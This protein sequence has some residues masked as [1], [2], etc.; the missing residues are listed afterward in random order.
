MAVGKP[1]VSV[2]PGV[3]SIDVAVSLT[4]DKPNR[5]VLERRSFTPPRSFQIDEHMVGESGAG[6][7]SWELSG[8]NNG[9]RDGTSTSTHIYVPSSQNRRV[10]AYTLAGVRDPDEDYILI[11]YHARG[12]DFVGT[13]LY[14]VDDPA[15]GT[16]DSRIYVYTDKTGTRDGS[17]EFALPQANGSPNGLYSDGTTLYIPDNDGH[18]Y[19]Y[20]ISTEAAGTTIDL[21]SD[22]TAPRGCY[23]D[24]TNLYVCDRL[25]DRV[26]IYKISDGSLVGSV[27]LAPGNAEARG[28]T[29]QTDWYVVNA[30]SGTGDV[31]TYPN[32][33]AT[34]LADYVYQDFFTA[35]T[36]EYEYRAI[37]DGVAGDWTP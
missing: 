23:G 27:A 22:N 25:S 6:V 3:A 34:A 31:F 37:A 8:D 33:A 14:A 12:I 26:Y 24:G 36:V 19:T 11:N 7:S 13:E 30:R 16:A 1:T 5:I 21:A 28:I 4:G 10:L 2:T 17:K 32:L 9:P 20:T 29:K 18:I 15:D 35:A